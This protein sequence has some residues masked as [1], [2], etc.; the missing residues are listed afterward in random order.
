MTAT[1]APA[2]V[3]LHTLLNQVIRARS[4]LARERHANHG[5]AALDSARAQMV[6]S[7]EAYTGALTNRHLPVPYALRDELRT[8]RGASR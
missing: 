8:Q 4:E 5:P 7:L 3:P 6:R 1:S 2:D